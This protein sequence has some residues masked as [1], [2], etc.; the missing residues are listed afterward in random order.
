LIIAEGLVKRFGA[1]TAVDGLSLEISAGETFG[2][3]GPNGAGKT[4]T[5]SMLIGLLSPDAGSVSVAGKNPRSNLVRRQIGIA[6]Q[7]LSLY[8]AMS[9][10]ENLQ[11]FGRMYGLFGKSLAQR[12]DDCLELAGLRERRKDRVGTF[13]GGMK[14][15]LNIAAGTIHVPQVLLL[16]E[17][18]VGVDPQ[19]RNHIIGCIQQLAKN[20]MTILYTTHYMEEAQKLCDRIGIMDQGRLLALGSLPKLIAEHGGLSVVSAEL[21]EADASVS[22]PGEL[23]QG[24]LRFQAKSPIEELAKLNSQGIQF[25]EIQISHPNLETVFLTLTGRSLRDE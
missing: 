14:R 12:V 23:H 5:I 18:T 4:T 2:L 22:L 13:S 8:E 7:A 21:I 11:F 15:R 6:P 10:E 1:R 24:V 20:G 16:D 3:L 19:S 17:P 9:A 25:G